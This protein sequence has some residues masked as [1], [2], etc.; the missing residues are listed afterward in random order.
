MDIFDEINS[1]TADELLSQFRLSVARDGKSYVC[2]I[3]QNGTGDTGDGIKPRIN[4]KGQVKWHG[5]KCDKDY[6]NFD[7]AAATLGYDSERELTESARALKER[8]GYSDKVI[9][10]FSKAKQS[11]R[12]AAGS[13]SRSVV[14]V[15][16]KKSASDKEP[17]NY[18]GLYKFCRENYDLKKFFDEQGGTWRGFTYEFAKSAGF[19]YHAEYMVGDGEIRE[20]LSAGAS[21]VSA[22]SSASPT[23]G[24]DVSSDAGVSAIKVSIS[25]TEFYHSRHNPYHSRKSG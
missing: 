15:S 22:S 23:S 17:K 21:A 14:N 20:A 25:I 8:L 16:E 5:F 18:A 19:L 9:F 3:C 13:D 1:W 11:S 2:P 4:S 10:S 6:S 24:P 7:L 12:P